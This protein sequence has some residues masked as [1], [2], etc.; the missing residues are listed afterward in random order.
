M[1]TKVLGK[2]SNKSN[3]SGKEYLDSIPRISTN[4]KH[5]IDIWNVYDFM[6]KNNRGVPHLK[7]LEIII[8]SN[9][10]FIVESKSMKL[11]L[12]SFYDI[13]FSHYSEIL[14]KIKHDLKLL[15]KDEVELKFLNKFSV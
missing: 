6:F 8:P 13:A 9:S 11:Y 3:I 7:V 12:N 14:K 4:I 5:G 2:K 10:K 15:I 1:K